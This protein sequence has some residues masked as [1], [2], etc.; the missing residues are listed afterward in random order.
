MRWINFSV[1]T[2]NNILFIFE[3]LK[4]HF[5]SGDNMNLENIFSC[6]NLYNAYKK[7]KRSKQ[8]KWE[9]IKFETNISENIYKLKKELT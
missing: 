8:H 6:E 7:F 3:G 5:F 9:V 1:H 4:G 2:N